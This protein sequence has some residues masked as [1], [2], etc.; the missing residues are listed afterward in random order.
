MK[1]II[2]FVIISFSTGCFYPKVTLDKSERKLISY[3]KRKNETF[4]SN[5]GLTDTVYYTKIGY[6][7]GFEPN[8]D[9]WWST[10]ISDSKRTKRGFYYSV[11]ATSNF[12][13][14]KYT[15]KN[16]NLY[17]NIR[18]KKVDNLDSLRLS[19]D[20]FHDEF[21]ILKNFVADTLIFSHPKSNDNCK[22]CLRRVTWTSKEGIITIEKK[23]GTIWRR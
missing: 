15:Q 12:P 4:Q 3:D 20:D 23:D 18:L 2:I 7:R 13:K 6:R 22:H 19:I 10:H 1:S 14:N 21:I 9:F 16:L 17:L 8:F 5:T 11:S